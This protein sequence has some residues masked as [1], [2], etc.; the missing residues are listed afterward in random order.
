MEGSMS[1]PKGSRNKDADTTPE[2]MLLTPEQRIDMLV[3]L[4]VEIV[5]EEELCSQ[6]S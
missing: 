1:R 2:A 4:L 3:T 6:T 5:V